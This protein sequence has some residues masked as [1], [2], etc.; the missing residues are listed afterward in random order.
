MDFIFDCFYE[1]IF[2]TLERNGLQS[3]QGRQNVSDQLDTVI[4]GCSAGE[5][6]VK[7]E[8]ESDEI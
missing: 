1:E 7:R 2:A 4:A 6:S 3:R 5:W 8:R